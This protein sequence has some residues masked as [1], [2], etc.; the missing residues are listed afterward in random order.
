MVLLTKN[1]RFS[2]MCDFVL[3]TCTSKILSFPSV[4]SLRGADILSFTI[5]NSKKDFPKLIL[6]MRVF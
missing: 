1:K 3:C 6:P 4:L 5:Y 2:Q